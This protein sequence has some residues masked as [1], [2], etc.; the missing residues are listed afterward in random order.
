MPYI[1]KQT[2]N[3]FGFM[4]VQA[5]PSLIQVNDYLVSSSE[6]SAISIGDMVMQTTINTARVITGAFVISSSAAVLGIAASAL[7]ANGGSTAATLNNGRSSQLL[8]VYDEPGQKFVVCDTT[9]GVIGTQLGLFKNY[10]VL[11]TGC[12]GSTGPNSTLKRSV[13]ALSGVESSAVG[14]FHV[15][16]LHPVEEGIHS[17][18]GA[19]TAGSAVNVRKWIGV[20]VAQVLNQPYS[21]AGLT[22][23]VNTTS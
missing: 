3:Y 14:P 8:K 18:V 16:G 2:N 23:I 20:L 5:G 9:S 21:S 1:Q 13:M 22:M 19:A 6:G 4:P 10:K 17:T 7:D 12:V 11:A 15:I